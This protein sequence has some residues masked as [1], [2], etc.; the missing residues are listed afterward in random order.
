MGSFRSICFSDAES[1]ESIKEEEF[2][3]SE[4]IFHHIK[5]SHGFHVAGDFR[6]HFR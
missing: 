2:E 5:D 1:K 3:A 4:L 6:L